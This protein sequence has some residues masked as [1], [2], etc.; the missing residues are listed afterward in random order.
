MGGYIYERV[1]AGTVCRDGI[2]NDF[3]FWCRHHLVLHDLT[4]LHPPSFHFPLVF[5]AITTVH[6]DG[7]SHAFVAG[8]YYYSKVEYAVPV[9]LKGYIPGRYPGTAP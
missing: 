8:K 5:Y 1:S 6:V 4:S 9:P 7:R 2:M 3:L